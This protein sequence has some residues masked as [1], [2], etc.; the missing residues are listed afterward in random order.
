MLQLD[1]QFIAEC[2][3]FHWELIIQTQDLSNKAWQV[4]HATNMAT[5]MNIGMGAHFKCKIFKGKLDLI[6]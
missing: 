5:I 4:K 2:K 3:G 1:F 6:P